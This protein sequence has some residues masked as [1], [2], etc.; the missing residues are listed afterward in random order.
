[1]VVASCCYFHMGHLLV[2]PAAAADFGLMGL[3]FS[4]LHNNSSHISLLEAYQSYL[5]R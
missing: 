3:T 4:E 2:V 1:M 5:V